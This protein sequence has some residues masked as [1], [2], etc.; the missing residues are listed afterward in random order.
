MTLLNYTEIQNNERQKMGLQLILCQTATRN[1]CRSV[2]G[3]T[4]S[5]ATTDCW[6]DNPKKKNVLLYQICM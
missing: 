3:E 2:H 4:L 6:C 1:H 5:S